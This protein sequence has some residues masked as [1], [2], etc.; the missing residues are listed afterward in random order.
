MAKMT[1]AEALEAVL[2][3]LDEATIAPGGGAALLVRLDTIDKR[4][5]ET[6]DL[7]RLLNGRVQEHGQT[8]A[9]HDQ[10]MESHQETHKTLGERVDRLSLKTNVVAGITGMMS[11]IAGA[12][13][14]AS[15]N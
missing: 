7:L 2:A 15:K 11:L 3:R 8:L 12:F 6:V 13:G 4:G 5:E 10:W 1:Y 9:G 14:V